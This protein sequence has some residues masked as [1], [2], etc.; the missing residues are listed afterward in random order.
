MLA[1]IDARG[2]TRIFNLGDYVGKG[3]GREVVDLCRA[4]CEVNILGTGR[5]PPDPDRAFD[6]DALE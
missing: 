6:T 2:I 1:D 4:R 3:R 5:L